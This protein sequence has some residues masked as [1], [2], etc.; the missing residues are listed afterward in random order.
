MNMPHE[1][2]GKIAYYS[3]QQLNM[4]IHKYIIKERITI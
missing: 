3:K 1:A 2:M 4:G